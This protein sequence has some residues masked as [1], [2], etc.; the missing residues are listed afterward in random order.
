MIDISLLDQHKYN[1]YNTNKSKYSQSDSKTNLDKIK[2]L[3][4]L[5]FLGS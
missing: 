2:D 1:N 4:I 5:N 3:N